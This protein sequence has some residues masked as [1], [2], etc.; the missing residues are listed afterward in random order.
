MKYNKKEISWAFYDWANSA[1]ATTV[2][3]GF[4]PI[5][6]KKYWAQGA[7]ISHSTFLLGLGNSLGSIIVALLAPILGAM[8][9]RGSSRKK[10]LLGFALLG[11]VMTGSLSLVAQGDWAFAITIFVMAFIGFAGANVFY[12]SFLVFVARE[13]RAHRVSALGYSLGYL[14]GGLLFTLNV[15][16]TMYPSTFFLADKSQAIK[17]SF[18]LVACWWLV[19]TIPLL[20]VVKEPG[21]KKKIPLA[22]MVKEGLKQF[23]QTFNKIR[24]LRVIFLFLLGY[25]FYIDGVDTVIRMA[26]DYGLSLGFKTNDLILALLITQFVGFPATLAFGHLGEKF[27]AKKGIYLGLVIYIGATIWAFFMTQSYEFYAL[28]VVIGLAQGGI[29]A[30]SRSLYASIIPPGQAAEFFGFYNM[31]GKF[32]AVLG[33]V[34]MGTVG[35]IT[36][37]PRLSILSLVIFFIIGGTFLFFVDEKEGKKLASELR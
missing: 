20:L 29:Q 23:T 37:S 26:V 28:A 17:V 7:D 31:L 33:P 9:D 22:N 8:A 25:W 11:I 4:F 14:G 2:M 3:A 18:F 15:L 30:L 24:K 32:A 19:F 27:G 34:L 10:F 6:F 13:D 35:L 16:M 12:D 1:F 36:K 5:F 21:E